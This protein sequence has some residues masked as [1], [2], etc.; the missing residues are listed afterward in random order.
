MKKVLIL[1]AFAGVLA[2]CH[3][4]DTQSTAAKQRTIDSL[5]SEMAKKEII[6]SVTRAVTLAQ[7]V[8]VAQPEVPVVQAADRNE[9]KRPVKTRRHTTR[10]SGGYTQS[11][12]NQYS[13]Y[14]AS[15]TSATSTT[16]TATTKERKGWS[17]KAKGAVIGAGA[18]AVAGALIDRKKGRGAIIGGL[19]GAGSG[20]GAG[21]IIDKRQQQQQ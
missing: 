18:G 19:L 4:G 14:A 6:D 2:S 21:A 13:G 10:N 1:A 7:P 15:P 5:K 16:T 11:Q 9:Y 17:A 3:S 8:A 12:S 20:L